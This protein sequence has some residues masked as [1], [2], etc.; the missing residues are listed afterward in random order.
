[1]S[2]QLTPTELAALVTTLLT[3]PD[4][5]GELDSTGKF[6]AFMTSIT[7]TVCEHVGGEVR[8]E[9]AFQD[10]VCYVGVHGNESLPDDGGVWKNFD[11]EGQLFA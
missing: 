10:G 8:N 6:A 5:L 11:K 7:E 9:A 1:M 4:A 3:N 2:K